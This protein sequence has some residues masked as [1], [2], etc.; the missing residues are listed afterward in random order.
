MPAADG[1]S[2]GRR[3]AWLSSLC[4]SW[5][6]ILSIAGVVTVIGVYGMGFATGLSMQVLVPPF[7]A[8]LPRI[9]IAAPCRAW[10]SRGSRVTSRG[11]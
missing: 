3:C 11:S 1:S 7:P 2:R 8:P 5:V 9:R 6:L 10:W 4:R